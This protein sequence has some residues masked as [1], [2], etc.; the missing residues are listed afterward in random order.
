MRL[1][2]DFVIDFAAK[3]CNNLIHGHGAEVFA[4]SVTNGSS[5][6]VLFTLADYEHVRSLLKL[7]FADFELHG[8]V[9]EV[10]KSG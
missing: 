2:S 6:F 1:V 3:L 5:V 7:C 8:F 4:L 9:A 10:W